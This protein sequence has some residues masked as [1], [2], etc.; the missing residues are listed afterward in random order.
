MSDDRLPTQS[1]NAVT[2]RGLTPELKARLRVRA[3]HNG[4]SME[5]EARAILEADLS[6]PDDETTDLGAFARGLIAPIGGIDLELPPEVRHDSHQNSMRRRRSQA[7]PSN[8]PLP[9]CPSSR[10][11][12]PARRP[13]PVRAP[14]ESAADDRTRHG[15]PGR[16]PEIR[17]GCVGDGVARGPAA[18]RA[19]HHHDRGGRDRHRACGAAKRAPTGRPDAGG[20]SPARRRAGWPHPAVR[21]SGRG[22]LR[23]PRPEASGSRGA[24]HDGGR[25]GRRHRQGARSPARRHARRAGFVA[26]GLKCVDP[27]AG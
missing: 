17:A 4:R 6:A 9:S 24:G 21:S 23:R 11:R 8:R 2:V 10:S 18:W 22:R 16:A 7:N 12:P 14:P 27:W 25:T 19:L 13:M 5:A 20:R 26:Q 1:G 15:G 3:A